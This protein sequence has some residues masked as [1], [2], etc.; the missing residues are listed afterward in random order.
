MGKDPFAGNPA[1]RKKR[2]KRKVEQGKCSFFGCDLKLYQEDL[3]HKHYLELIVNISGQEIQGFVH[4]CNRGQL[5]LREIAARH[6]LLSKRP[7]NSTS[8]PL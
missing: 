2:I 1:Q 5:D 6:G 4:F 7:Q 8:P 3:C